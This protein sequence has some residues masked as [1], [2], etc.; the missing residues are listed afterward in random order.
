MITLNKEKATFGLLCF[1]PFLAFLSLGFY[2]YPII[3]RALL[4]IEG[5]VFF[6]ILL[7][8]ASL[9]GKWHRW[10]ILGLNAVSV[11]ITLI[12]HSGIGVALAFFNLFV[13]ILI[14]N[15]L[16]LT[17]EK[18]RFLHFLT[19]VLLLFFYV[20]SNFGRLY[21]RITMRDFRGYFL[22]SNV[23]GMLLLA[24]L[25]HAFNYVNSL[26]IDQKKKNQWLITVTATLGYIIILSWC[27]SAI[28]SLA[29]FLG[30]LALVRFYKKPITYAHYK[31][32]SL[33]ILV[34]SILFTI[35]YVYLSYHMSDLTILNKKLFTGR[36]IVWQS[37]Y[38][39]ISET[40]IFGH[41]TD[42]LLNTVGGEKTTSAHNMLLSF[43]YTLGVIPMLS[44][45]LLFV[46]RSRKDVEYKRDR[47]T[48]F[49]L[50][51]SLFIC[52]FE[53]FYAD[54]NL[55]IFFSLLLLSNIKTADAVDKE[56]NK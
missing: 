28:I 38:G 10:A 46:N 2:S 37:A 32:V 39:L 34:A 42:V 43:W 11:A 35:V 8:N 36:E 49:A 21:G 45:A 25:F 19:A 44:T 24:L 3:S 14:F 9:I 41:G 20:L 29:A 47:I 33:M 40:P 56:K 26:E 31:I 7:L 52:F 18:K 51:A 23:V 16:A 30:L 27:R 12:L 53:S 55:Q 17:V 22:N 54:P 48:Q 13:A 5:A 6:L 4:L 1:L 50:I 15:N